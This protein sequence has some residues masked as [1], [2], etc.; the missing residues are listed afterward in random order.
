MNLEKL[1]QD[2]RFSLSDLAKG[3]KLFKELQ[4]QN[5]EERLAAIVSIDVEKESPQSPGYVDPYFLYGKFPDYK[6]VLI[7]NIAASAHEIERE[8]LAWNIYSIRRP[9]G[10]YEFFT[11]LLLAW[12][13]EE[14][15]DAVAY[16]LYLGLLYRSEDPVIK[17]FIKS[18][19]TQKATLADAAIYFLQL[20][21]EAY[22]KHLLAKPEDE[23]FRHDLWSMLQ[24]YWTAKISPRSTRQ[25]RRRLGLAID[26][27][28]IWWEDIPWQQAYDYET[29][30]KFLK[31]K[32]RQV[33]YEEIGEIGRDGPRA[34]VLK[35]NGKAY[36]SS[37]YYQI[38]DPLIV[39]N[40]AKF[41]CC[42]DWKDRYENRLIFFNLENGESQIF[43]DVA[44]HYTPYQFQDGYFWV[45]VASPSREEPM[46]LG[47]D[48]LLIS[49]SEIKAKF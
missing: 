45:V 39:D 24:Q 20:D 41:L 44:P 22:F 46:K 47:E 42:V 16:H 38:G 21:P 40:E 48:V 43:A 4:R 31:E 10:F 14:T 49:L 3:E 11:P 32:N 34:G 27:K 28:E 35:I 26:A 29:T 23:V 8:R 6:K 18:Q 12:V 1:Y 9:D 17:S 2:F 30:L 15:S 19:L 37:N 33:A 5:P 13:Q 36:Q 7:L 25:I